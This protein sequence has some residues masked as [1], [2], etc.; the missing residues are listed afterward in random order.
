MSKKTR[1]HA[2]IVDCSIALMQGRQLIDSTTLF[3][4]FSIH[5]S[6]QWTMDDIDGVISGVGTWLGT[7]PF[8]KK[9]KNK[10]KK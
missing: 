3:R 8:L 6:C 9:I 4:Y 7:S 5:T 2:R 1:D 10:I